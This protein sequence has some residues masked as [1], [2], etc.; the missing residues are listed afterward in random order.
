MILLP[1]SRPWTQQPQEAPQIIAVPGLGLPASCFLASMQRDLLLNVTPTA[2]ATK[3]QPIGT[4][5]IGIVANGSGSGLNYNARPLSGGPVT[6]FGVVNMVASATVTGIIWNQR[7][8]SGNFS[9][10]N[11][12]ANLDETGVASS[13][14]LAA[15]VRL[16]TAA[17]V[18]R[19]ISLSN[20]LHAVAF[21]WVSGSTL[22]WSVDGVTHTEEASLDTGT[23]T[24]W[25]DAGQTVTI[26]GA[27]G[28]S[29]FA[30]YASAAW[31]RGT[32]QAALNNLTANPWQL[33]E[34]Q[35]IWV[36]VSAGGGAITIDGNLG[37]ATAAGT[38]GQVGVAITVDASTG[39]A[40]AAGTTAQVGVSIDIT[41]SVGNAAAAGV[42]GL[43]GV[44][45]DITATTGN[46]VAA[47]ITGVV[48]LGGSI[49][50]D[51]NVGAAVA[52][53]VQG[54]PGVTITIDGAAGGAVAAGVSGGV[55]VTNDITINATAG[56]AVAVGILAGLSLDIEVAGVIGN[57]TAAG[58]TGTVSLSGSGTGATAAEIWSYTLSNGLTAEAT[59]VAVHTMLSEL[60]LIHGL[61]LGSPLSVT[62]ASRA[63]GAVSQA[64]AEAA[65]TVTVTRQ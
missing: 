56:N 41:G 34:P 17:R 32:S 49:T 7:L 2:T 1:Y 63:A 38:A 55:T 28:T 9:Q 15:L 23:V 45:L 24:T 33:F 35:R 40:T 65:G 48:D 18:Q 19:R 25:L 10:C 57:A 44:S 39:N 8:G 61:T 3:F 30:I 11:L 50:I 14:K 42:T 52:A 6:V 36:P 22:L 37:N 29:E 59:L 21:S 12:V 5:G 20:G 16:S 51:G 26:L 13:G 46:A 60:H 4:C 54:L 27:G 31:D 47:G 53:G 43:P 64:V 62:A 58:T